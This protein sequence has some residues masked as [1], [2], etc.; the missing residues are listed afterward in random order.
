MANIT[1]KT[2]AKR[3]GFSVTTVSRALKNG[4]EIS[5]LQI[6]DKI[7]FFEQRIKNEKN[8]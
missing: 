7:K 6:I 1:L 8:Y 2:L 5:K 3:T 4:V